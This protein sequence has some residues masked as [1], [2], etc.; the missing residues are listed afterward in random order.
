MNFAPAQIA[1]LDESTA[2]WIKLSA[3]EDGSFSVAN[4]RTGAIKNYNAR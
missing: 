4:G 3:N 1:N 2:Y